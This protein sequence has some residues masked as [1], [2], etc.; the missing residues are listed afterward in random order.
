MAQIHHFAYGWIT[1]AASF[2]LSVLGSLL[3]LTLAVKFRSAR[4]RGERTWWLLLAALAIG[5]TAIWCMHFVAMLGFEVVGTP[6]RYDV[7]RTATSALIAVVAVA[8]GLTI[9]LPGSRARNVRVPLGG[10]LAGL[11][12]AAM[13]Y[14]GMAAMRLNGTVGYDL[15][16]V[17]LSVGIAVGAASVALWLAVTVRKPLAILAS[18][19]IMGGAVNGMHFTGMTAMSV[20][21]VATPVPPVGATAGVLLVPIAIAVA[22]VLLGLVYAIMAAPTDED[23][24]A[25][26]YL[27]AR[28]A[29]AGGGVA[30]QPATAAP[31][32]ERP[33]GPRPGLAAGQWAHRDPER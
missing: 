33:T 17:G 18:A 9:A 15:R 3:G 5:G 19:L 6:I 8:A 32:G 11:G 31:A 16:R 21:P 1:P 7:A 20:V 28:Q 13:H 27:A 4:S 29:Q 23:R 26:A 2:V 30:R 22:F 10:V 14:T 25:A 24:A 12:I